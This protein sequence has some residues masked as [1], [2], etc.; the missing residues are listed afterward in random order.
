MDLMK[1]L[2][3]RAKKWP[4]I[5]QV[6]SLLGVIVAL[7]IHKPEKEFG[8]WQ[9]VLVLALA[10]LFHRIGTTLD[11]VVFGPLYGLEPSKPLKRVWR[12]VARRLFFIIK[13]VVD[14]LPGTREMQEKR[15][16]AAGTLRCK[17][18]GSKFTYQK[19][20][21]CEGV[22]DDAKVLLEKSDEWDDH[23][24]PWLEL[25]K[26]IRSFIW[27]LTAI[28]I[29]DVGHDRWPM[30]WLDN[31]LSVSV[32]NW[33]SWWAVSISALFLALVLYI[34]LRILHMRAMY[35]LVKESKF[36]LLPIECTEGAEYRT[37]LPARHLAIGEKS[38]EP[39][40][41]TPVFVLIPM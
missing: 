21:N 24:K 15:S 18:A 22:Y 16:E 6:A 7:A 32:L 35:K 17:I 19:D 37:A 2:E 41:A 14:R 36:I 31:A 3:K 13:L 9:T 8:L 23:I 25:S 28:F 20:V 38:K 34:W 27:P 26:A 40:Q 5:V 33:L 12:F 30:P 39:R 11:A 29:Y 4:G 10:V 1:A